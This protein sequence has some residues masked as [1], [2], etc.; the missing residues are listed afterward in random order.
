MIRNSILIVEDDPITVL[1]LKDMLKLRGYDIIGP[2]SEGACAIETAMRERPDLILMDVIIDGEMDGID[3]AM[4]I[5]TRMDV[6]VVYL[7]A[8]TDET[9]LKRAQ[10]TAPYGYLIKPVKDYDLYSTI[11]TALTRHRLERTIKESE[12]FSSS[13][14][15]S[16]P[17]PVFVINLDSSIRYVNTAFEALTGF[18]SAEVVGMRPPYP[19]HTEQ[20][21]GEESFSRSPGRKEERYSTKIGE[22]FT[23]EVTTVP[24]SREEALLYSM[25]IWVDITLRRRLEEQI[26][27]ISERERIRIGHDLHDGIGQELTA[28]GYLFAG[29]VNMMRRGQ[30][31]D[32]TA[33]DSMMKQLD[34]AKSHVRLLAKG[35]SPVHMDRFGIAIAIDELCRS[36]ERIYGI[37]CDVDCDDIDI[38]DNSRATHMYYIIQESLNN[39]VKHG[40]SKNIRVAFKRRGAGLLLSVVDDGVGLPETAGRPEGLGLM[41]MRYRADI[42]GGVLTVKR[43]KPSGTIVSCFVRSLDEERA[44]SRGG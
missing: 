28:V 44:S 2:E 6:P 29:M 23:V 36:A 11:E 30:C 19:W 25:V 33:I 8:S 42:I 3:A 10:N 16:M 43:R 5:Q 9:N 26:L 32:E 18:G 15:S 40:K 12:A 22:P 7:T 27:D 14:M 38:A 24:V 35:L 20:A 41:F 21:S 1:N 37:R 13:L 34:R 39:A 4:Q 31:A 17:I